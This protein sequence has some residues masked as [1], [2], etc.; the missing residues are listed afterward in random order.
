MLENVLHNTYCQDVAAEPGGK[1]QY[2]EW[3]REKAI[4]KFFGAEEIVFLKYKID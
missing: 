4:G 3:D 1:N 2:I